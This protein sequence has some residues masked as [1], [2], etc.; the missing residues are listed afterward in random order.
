MNSKSTLNRQQ[1]PP[2]PALTAQRSRSNRIQYAGCFILFLLVA[3]Y[4]FDHILQQYSENPTNENLLLAVIAI[5]PF[6]AGFYM[7][8][9]FLVPKV[10]FFEDHLLARSLWGRTRQRSYQEIATLAVKHYNL[11]IT[12]K[13]RSKIALHPEEIDL[14]HL[15]RWLTERDVSAARDI[16]ATWDVRK[17]PQ[18]TAGN[19]R[20]KQQAFSPATLQNKATSGPVLTLRAPLW[21]RMLSGVFLGG[22]LLVN[23][24]AV[25]AVADKYFETLDNV[26]IFW[27]VFLTLGNGIWIPGLA[28]A[29]IPKEELY[30][31][32]VLIRSMWGR[33]RRLSYQEI[34]KVGVLDDDLIITF[35]YI[36][37]I[38]IDRTTID[39]EDF[40]RWLAERSVI[41]ARALKR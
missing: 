11:F 30:E 7:L 8:A 19:W 4:G 39:E 16:A 5:F 1:L 28:Y 23:V 36:E 34:T 37:S 6:F 38:L 12:F 17:E 15:A 22:M 24:F 32:H 33:S 29:L 3:V 31:D 14:D 26:W 41:A 18:R 10:E 25:Y 20:P 9:Y 35:N 40:A 21:A 2:S 13:D 27:T